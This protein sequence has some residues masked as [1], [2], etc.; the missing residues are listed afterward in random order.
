LG[1]KGNITHIGIQDNQIEWIS[2]CAQLCLILN[3]NNNDLFTIV[4]R[5]NYTVIV[6][7]DPGCQFTADFQHCGVVHYDNNVDR[8][9]HY[10]EMFTV[11]HEISDLNLEDHHERALATLPK[12]PRLDDLCR[13]HVSTKRI[14]SQIVIPTNSVSFDEC[15]H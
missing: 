6:Q 10:E 12:V 11:L 3:G 8:N 2:P 9:V 15:I 4:Q 1:S 14:N 13:L 5:V 7:Y